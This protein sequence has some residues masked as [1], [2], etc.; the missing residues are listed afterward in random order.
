[1]STR[2]SVL[3]LVVLSL[4]LGLGRSTATAQS[5]QPCFTVASFKG[6]YT[7][8]AN[9]GANVAI[10]LGRRYVDVNGNL[11]GTFLVNK[12]TPGST[13]GERTIVTG[14]HGGYITV[15]CDGTGVITRTLTVNGVQTNQ[16]DDFVVSGAVLK[17]GQLIVTSITDAQR[18]PSA[19][20]AGGIFLTRVWTRIPE[21]PE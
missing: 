19:I 12:P 5:Q 10:G 15:N 17:E 7:A 16:V 21:T 4:S 14:T 18:T 9:Y 20:V 3:V 1:M 8:I 13:T 11:T 2:K 6:S